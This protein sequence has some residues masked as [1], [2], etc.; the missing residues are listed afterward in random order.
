MSRARGRLGLLVAALVL[1]LPLAGCVS[2]GTDRRTGS[3]T[4]LLQPAD[5]PA[6]VA[7][8][9]AAVPAGRQLHCAPASTG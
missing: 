7:D 4:D 1:A 9:L 5:P 2:A 6:A 3:P 8:Q